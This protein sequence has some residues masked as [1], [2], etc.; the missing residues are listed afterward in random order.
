MWKQEDLIKRG[1]RAE[2]EMSL[3]EG[4]PFALNLFEDTQ[5]VPYMYSHYEGGSFPERAEGVRTLGP[6]DTHSEAQLKRYIAL[7]EDLLGERDL[8]KDHRIRTTLINQ[9]VLEWTGNS[10]L[11]SVIL[12]DPG[13]ELRLILDQQNKGD[14]RWGYSAWFG[15][16]QLSPFHARL[17]KKH[18]GY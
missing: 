16:R 3:S 10:F 18:L 6:T 11:T 15:E 4:I 5:K 12:V 7:L 13:Y 2:S 8:S 9:G 17:R 14:H 1:F